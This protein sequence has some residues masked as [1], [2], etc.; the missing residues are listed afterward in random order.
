MTDVAK[1]TLSVINYW[2]LIQDYLPAVIA[3]LILVYRSVFLLAD[4]SGKKQAL[5]LVIWQ[6]KT[7]NGL[8]N[9]SLTS[10]QPVTT[11]DAASGRIK[12]LDEIKAIIIIGGKKK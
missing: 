2:L 7:F 5:V 3:N 11:E 6:N 10:S 9:A 12:M 1:E 8:S 4:S